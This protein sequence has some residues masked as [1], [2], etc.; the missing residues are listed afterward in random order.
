MAQVSA[1]MRTTGQRRSDQAEVWRDISE[2]SAKFNVSSE[3]SA[4]S[5]IYEQES[6]RLEDYVHSFSVLEGQ[7]GAV[8]AID[9][10]VVGLELFDSAETLRKLFPKLLR[11]YGLDALDRARS[12]PSRKETQCAPEKAG[13][14]LEKLRG[15]SC[16]WVAIGS[17]RCKINQVNSPD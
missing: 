10:R 7:A 13:A 4:V 15:G 12:K 3:T 9:G 11:S 14:F 5:D 17:D 2:K 16:H 1:S 8:F 6:T